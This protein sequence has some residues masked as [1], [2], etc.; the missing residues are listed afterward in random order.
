VVT[1]RRTPADQPVHQVG[2]GSV[3]VDRSPRRTCRPIGRP[4]IRVSAAGP[5]SP[6]RTVPPARARVHGRDMQLDRDRRRVD[7]RP[8]RASTERACPA[9]RQRSPGRLECGLV[10]AASDCFPLRTHRPCQLGGPRSARP[11]P[12]Q[13]FQSLVCTP[14]AAYNGRC[15][16]GHDATTSSACRLTAPRVLVDQAAEPARSRS[17]TCAKSASSFARRCAR[18]AGSLCQNACRLV[19]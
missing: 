5:P 18:T 8:H 14:V 10:G 2:K 3:H 9:C 15:L 11:A 17:A 16:R 13:P 19:W 4:A 7:R 6:R 1:P 12:A